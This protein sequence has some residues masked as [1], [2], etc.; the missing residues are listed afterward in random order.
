M[1]MTR[2]LLI[3]FSLLFVNAIL[4]NAQKKVK[5]KDLI[6]LLNAKQYDQA[7]PFLK[8]YIKDN[9]D[10]PNAYLFL[11]IIFQEK[12]L[13]EDVLKETELL[14]QHAD[15]AILNLETAN[16]TIDEREIRRNDEYYQVYNR[17]DLR[18]GEFGVKLSDVKLD[19]EK[20]IA[21]VKERKQN[22]R[23]LK[24]YFIQAEQKYISSVKRFQ[25]VKQGLPE[26][27]F[28]LLSSEKT[29]ETLH[30][31][32]LL[33]DSFTTTFDNYKAISKLTVKA[34]Y[35]QVL[36]FLPIKSYDSDGLGT[37]DF[38][39]DEVPVW[40]FKAWANSAA[41]VIANDIEPI[42]I[43]L[44][45]TDFQLNLLGEKLKKDSVSV[46]KQIE[47]A[48]SKFEVAKLKK[49]DSNPLP[50][51]IFDLKV[52]E[53]KYGSVVV[54]NKMTRDS[55]D[56]NFKF[57]LTQ[58]ELRQANRLDSLA[59]LFL[60]RDIEKDAMNYQ[61]FVSKAYGDISV[62]K[63]LANALKEYGANESSKKQ[64]ELE[65]RKFSLSWIISKADSIP[66]FSDSTVR[67][68]QHQMLSI[69][70]EHF[71][72]GLKFG[73]D[74]L[75]TGYF[76][77]ITPS[78]IADVS[79]TFNV[80]KI[81]FKKRNLSMI[82]S[83]TKTDGKDQIYFVLI[84][85]EG[86]IKDKYAASIAK[87]YRSDGLAWSFNYLLD[88]KPTELIFVQETG[89]LS[90]KLVNDLGETKIVVIDKSGRLIKM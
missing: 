46:N 67:R 72:A 88:S 71:T 48:I 56:V 47:D 22:V 63:K 65:R 29:K 58:N 39:K 89:E 35:N 38:M 87:I 26:N 14:I 61:D 13:K 86:K 3:L 79:A 70:K 90:I 19:I 84:F 50:A 60:T 15:S 44:T 40:N 41:D 43:E 77:T 21:S 10:N 59:S 5:Y 75:A 36:K 16:K 54:E 31:F 74:S 18:T 66:L 28:Y 27:K 4:V 9:N 12:T 55:A 62:I 78:R 52:A 33:Y 53:L 76:Y 7:E 8:K 49:Y 45:K 51:S 30:N 42:R 82:R 34:G 80:D 69:E 68:R 23:K 85:S 20:R 32:I 17:R 24:D 64:Q 83:L 6:I 73:A 11:G 25:E 81:N 57:L 37:S 1:K 2:S